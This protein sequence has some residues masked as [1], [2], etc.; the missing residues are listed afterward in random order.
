[1][2]ARSELFADLPFLP[3]AFSL[4]AET[5]ADESARESLLD[6]AMGPNRRRK[7][8]EA[9]RRDRLPAEGLSLVAESDEGELL[10]TVRL[11]NV[12][13]GSREGAEVPALLLGPLA[14]STRCE[15]LGIGSALMR[16][17]IA[18]SRWRGHGA[19]VLVGD[20]PFYERFGFAADRAADLAMPGPFERHRLLGLEL[21]DGA[22]S[23]ARGAI[24]PTGRLVET[25]AAA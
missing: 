25:L 1:M 3:P 13:A 16:R 12:S 2:F 7:S 14:V 21:R 22:L 18:E 5:A 15:G 11:W 6:A 4:R 20:A 8:S 23:G 9:I 17:A 10:G 24:V 19:I